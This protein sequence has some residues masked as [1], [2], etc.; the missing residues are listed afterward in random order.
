MAKNKK[1][2]PPPPLCVWCSAPWTD[3]M[4]KV[5]AK[6]DI[7]NGYYEGEYTVIGYDTVVDVTCSSCHKLVYRKEIRVKGDYAQSR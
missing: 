4:L 3:D 5:Y 7:E 6:A 1:V 2:S